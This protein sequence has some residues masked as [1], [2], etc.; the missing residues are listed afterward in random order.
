MGWENGRKLITRWT[1]YSIKFDAVTSI[2]TKPLFVWCIAPQWLPAQI[3]LRHWQQQK[4]KQKH[5]LAWL[6][7]KSKPRMCRLEQLKG[8]H[9][10][11]QF[12]IER[13]SQPKV[14]QPRSCGNL[15]SVNLFMAGPKV[16]APALEYR[17][18]TEAHVHM[19]ICFPSHSYIQGCDRHKCNKDGSTGLQ[20]RSCIESLVHL[21]EKAISMILLLAAHSA[22]RKYHW[23]FGGNLGDWPWRCKDIV[24]NTLTIS[25]L[26]NS[27]NAISIL[28]VCADHKSFFWCQTTPVIFGSY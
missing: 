4:P 5:A 1:I 10:P 3:R 19:Y 27:W 11:C 22:S 13:T 9:R 7:P 17:Y 25:G 23:A 26:K 6:Q 14:L 12:L 28:S 8:T 15:S 24:E 16:L 21:W 20:F 2:C 18:K